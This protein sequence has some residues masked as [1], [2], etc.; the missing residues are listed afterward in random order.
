MPVDAWVKLIFSAA[1]VLAVGFAF[2][3]IARDSTPDGDSSGAQLVK[4]GDVQLQA[5]QADAAA[6]NARVNRAVDDLLSLPP[7]RPP[8][9]IWRAVSALTDDERGTCVFRIK[10]TYT[11]GESLKP[12]SGIPASVMEILRVLEG[13]RRG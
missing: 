12:G 7:D 2:Y 11:I 4:T 5:P 1:V 9:R 10:Q 3:S 13:P 8:V 6:S